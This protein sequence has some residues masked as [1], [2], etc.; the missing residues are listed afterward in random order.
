MNSLNETVLV[1]ESVLVMLVYSGSSRSSSNAAS[2]SNKDMDA[3]DGANRERVL[4]GRIAMGPDFA[5]KTQREERSRS[6]DAI[7]EMLISYAIHK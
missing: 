6:D 7:V 3:D 5:A 1:L 2:Y 4:A